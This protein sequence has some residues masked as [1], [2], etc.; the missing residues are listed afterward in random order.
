MTTRLIFALALAVAPVFFAAPALCQPPATAPAKAADVDLT[1]RFAP[2]Q[3]ALYEVATSDSKHSPDFVRRTARLEVLRITGEG[4]VLRWT[5]YWEGKDKSVRPEPMG[6]SH[7][8]TAEFTVDVLVPHSGD[9]ATAADVEPARAELIGRYTAE[10]R[11]RGKSG[12]ALTN[13]VSDYRRVLAA[14]TMVHNILVSD[15]GLL[16]NGL[17]HTLPAGFRKSLSDE[18]SMDPA[19]PALKRSVTFT[20]KT[21]DTGARH[22]LRQK[23]SVSGEQLRPW[24][25]TYL[26]RTLKTPGGEPTDSQLTEMV[27]DMKGLNGENSTIYD[28]ASGWPAA[29]SLDKQST[30]GPKVRR[31]TSHITLIEGPDPVVP[32]PPGPESDE[33]ARWLVALVA[34]DRAPLRWYGRREEESIE[35]VTPSQREILLQAAVAP[36]AAVNGEPAAATVFAGAA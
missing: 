28:S 21:D 25:R 3:V 16:F 18:L 19:M 29:L 8:R 36:H 35:R 10:Q 30:D 2:G 27:K 33:Y 5:D 1:P 11:A 26:R 22:T 32:P 9:D 13:A 12:A 7:K 17:N 6:E 24:M 31:Q 14:D 34:A 15:F 4:A 23:W 20:L